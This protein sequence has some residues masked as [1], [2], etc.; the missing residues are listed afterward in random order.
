MNLKSL[1]P[2]PASTVAVLRQNAGRLEV[3]LIRRP[4]RMKFAAGYYVFPGGSLEPQ[5]LGPESFQR[6]RGID[7]ERAQRVLSEGPWGKDHRPAGGLGYWTGAVRELFE[8]A[9]ILLCED[10]DGRVVDLSSEIRATTFRRY[11]AAVL[12]GRLSFLE[13]LKREGLYYAAGSL[14][15]L[16]RWV[17]PPPSPVRFDARFFA[18]P[19]P[20][21]QVASP[22]PGEASDARWVAVEEAI[23]AEGT[24]SLRMLYPTYDTLQILLRHG[25]FEA[26]MQARKRGLREV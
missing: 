21:S 13:L 19:L 20:K 6:C 12:E 3:F 7:G 22:W 10:E 5:D 26:L 4:E 8:E 23:N 17:T 25:S 16:T 24:A 11:R 15:Y 14:V 2:R 18:C 9:G 1:A